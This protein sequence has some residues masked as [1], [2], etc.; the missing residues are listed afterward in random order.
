MI[1]LK[2][3]YKK[4]EA[5]QNGILFGIL[6]GIGIVGISTI[7]TNLLI[8][9]IPKLNSYSLILYVIISIFMI[10][11]TSLYAEGWFKKVHVISSLALTLSY[12][13]YRLSGGII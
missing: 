11:A 13:Y 5:H 9:L 8:F 2:K 6:S 3:L 4:M 10:Y 12:I 1:N 7:L